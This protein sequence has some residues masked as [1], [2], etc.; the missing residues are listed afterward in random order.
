M[1]GVLLVGLVAGRLDG[2]KGLG[3]LAGRAEHQPAW[4]Q[5]AKKANGILVWVSNSV[6]S[7]TVSLCSRLVRSHFKSFV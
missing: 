1:P 5:E 2:E 3:I 7:R 6:A 4:T